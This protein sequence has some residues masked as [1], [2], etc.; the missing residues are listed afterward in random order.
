MDYLLGSDSLSI[1]TRNW[2][3]DG[4]VEDLVKVCLVKHH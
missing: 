2:F 1:Y 3:N 4:F